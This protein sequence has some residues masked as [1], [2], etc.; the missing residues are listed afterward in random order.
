MPAYPDPGPDAAQPNGGG[1]G[2]TYGGGGGDPRLGWYPPYGNMPPEAYSPPRVVEPQPP[3]RVLEP[4]YL[5]VRS[6]DAPPPGSERNGAQQGRLSVGSVYRPNQNG[7]GE[8]VQAPG[9]SS[10]LYRMPPPP[11]K[12]RPPPWPPS[13]AQVLP[14]PSPPST[15]PHGARIWPGRPRL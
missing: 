10:I 14:R 3:F 5:P 9:A 11:A 15:H 13:A 1:G 4:P 2:G 7:R 8:S 6:S 12:S